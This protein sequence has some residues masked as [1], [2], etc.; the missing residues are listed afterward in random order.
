MNF[1]LRR[2]VSRQ[3]DGLQQEFMR[4]FLLA[5]EQKIVALPRFFN[6]LHEFVRERR[7]PVASPKGTSWNAMRCPAIE[8]KEMLT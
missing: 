5:M 2:C 4:L 3:N 7:F 8:T 1:P 6:C